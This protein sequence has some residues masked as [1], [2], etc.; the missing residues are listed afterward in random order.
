[1]ST[2]QSN[3]SPSQ[4]TDGAGPLSPYDAVMVVSFGGP[5]KPDD[6]VPFLRNVTA[7]KNIPDERLKEVG[8]HYYG[9]GG[10]SPINAQNQDLMEALA[11]ELAAR[12]AELPVVIGNRNWE[13][14][15]PD[16]LAT[17]TASGAK[18][19]VCVVTSAYSSYSGCRQYRENIAQAVAQ[20]PGAPQLDRIRHYFNLPGFVEAITEGVQRCLDG[21][22]PQTRL[23]FVTHS[24]PVAMND[25]SGPDGGAYVSQHQDV[26]SSV[27]AG[28]GGDYDHDLVFCSRSG[29]PSMPWLE[30]DV[31][32]HLEELAQAGVRHVV[33]VPIGFISDHMEVAYD[34][35]TEA[36]ATAQ[37]LGITARRAPTAGTHPAFVKGLVDL[38]VERAALARGEH[39]TREVIGDLPPAGEYCA[40][41]C[42]PNLRADK[43]AIWEGPRG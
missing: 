40:V 18:R 10:R 20:T 23:V 27:V 31:N 28:L 35:D 42:C 30:P 3:F 25:S 13:P 39:A 41:G 22:P 17:L 37:R 33:M 34:L 4:S 1:M 36:M 43:S 19:V 6:V 15:L 12:G 11:A 2:S 5:E 9:F 29:P 16:T 26:M 38:L 14:Y 32:D 7:G 24:I 8:E 21:M